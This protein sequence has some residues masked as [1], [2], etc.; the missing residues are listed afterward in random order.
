MKIIHFITS[1]DREK[2]G[3][4]A[5]LNILSTYLGKADDLTIISSHGK[6]PLPYKNAKIIQLPLSLSNFFYFRRSVFK[7]FSQEKPDIIH[8]NGIW[9]LPTIFVQRFAQSHNIPVI[10]SPHGS[11]EPYVLT[12]K[13]FKKKLALSVYQKKALQK[14]NA[15]HA[16]ANS[17][18]LNI[19][20]LN[21][22]TPIEA[23]PNPI[24]TENITIRDNWTKRNTIL[25]LSRIDPKK[26]LELLFEVIAN[27]SN[28]TLKLIIAG[29]GN[30]EYIN[31]LKSL[32]VSLNIPDR[33]EFKGGVYGNEKW[34][35]Y[36]SVDAFVLPTYSENF[37]IVIGEALICGTPVIT[38]KGTPWNYLKTHNC[39]WWINRDFNSL[40]DA[41]NELNKK[42]SDELKIMGANGRN[43][44]LSNFSGT[45]I[46]NQ[47]LEL[48]KKTIAKHES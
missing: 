11:L 31:S 35:L 10:I 3:A 1:I 7:I 43:L 5:F 21:I 20:K 4:S 42:S 8:I 45:I 39:G 33:I 12:K 26:G 40:L 38:T 16:T 14:A 17:E 44:I 18:M 28:K 34:D 27:N 32:A 6:N 48:Y 25:F 36:K 37:G 46:A 24:E 15:L 19:K 22:T 9:D 47:M 29:E 41:I 30:A 23:I 13:S 2:G